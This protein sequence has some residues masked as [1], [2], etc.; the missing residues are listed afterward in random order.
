M[1]KLISR[2]WGEVL[3]KASA[4]HGDALLYPRGSARRQDLI[5]EAV[6]LVSEWRQEQLETRASKR[7]LACYVAEDIE[8]RVMRWDTGTDLERVYLRDQGY[9]GPQEIQLPEIKE[10]PDQDQGDEAA[11][12]LAAVETG[13]TPDGEPLEL[14]TD[15][16]AKLRDIGDRLRTAPDRTPYTRRLEAQI[17]AVAE[18]LRSRYEGSRSLSPSTE[19]T[20]GT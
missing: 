4:L 17:V 3:A 13:R 2:S 9:I 15:T 6:A 7:L 10:L 16:A 8:S 18:E 20:P 11:A 1:T 5:K 14:T 19:G 12:F